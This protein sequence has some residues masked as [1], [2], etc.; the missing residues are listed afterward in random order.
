MKKHLFRI[1]MIIFSLLLMIGKSYASSLGKKDIVIYW[2]ASNS[3]GKKNKT[4]EFDFL[5]SFFKRTP[6]VEVTLF[7]FNTSIILEESLKVED[8]NWNYLKQLLSNVTYDGDSDFSLVNTELSTELLF[9]FTDGKCNFG[10]FKASLYSPRIITISSQFDIDKKFLHNTAYYNRG[11]YVNLLESDISSS[12][13]AVLAEETLAKLEFIGAEEK[14]YSQKYIKGIVTDALDVLPNVNVMILEKNIK[15][16]TD[17]FGRYSIKAD[18]G[19]VL[20]FSSIDKKN[21]MVEVG[22]EDIIDIR[23]ID[24]INE[25]EPVIIKSKSN[26]D[27]LEIRIGDKWVNRNS[28]GYDVKSLESKDFN[29][30]SRSLGDAIAGKFAGVKMGNDND[31]GQMIIRSNMSYL[32]S[33]NPVFV[34]DGVPLTR[35]TIPLSL[36][37]NNKQPISEATAYEGKKNFNFLDPNS[38]QSIT[39][40][41][42][43]AATNRYGQLGNNGIVLITTKVA[44]NRLNLSQKQESLQKMKYDIYKLP[45]FINNNPKSNFITILEKTSSIEQGYQQYLK[46]KNFHR[47]NVTFFIESAEFFFSKGERGIGFRIL[48]NL[49]ELFPEDTSVLKILAFHLE[50]YEM[51]EQAQD[52]YKLI[53]EISPTISQAYL[54]LANSYYDDGKHQKSVDLFLKISSK[55]IRKVKSFNGLQSQINNDFKSLLSHR[56]T[57][58]KLN[59]IEPKYFNLPKY[60]IRIVTEWSHPQTEFE[61]Q[62]INP[63]KQ[64]FVLSH[65]LEKYKKVMDREW[66]EEFTSEE[67]IIA[68]AEKGK[69]F[70]GLKSSLEHNTDVKYPKFLKVK[71]YTNFGG[72]QEK[73]QTHII[74]LDR[75]SEDKIFAYFTVQ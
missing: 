59:K 5:D 33:S 7:I 62:Y 39:V 64:Y 38:I 16:I 48:S 30:L 29:N 26:N 28:V 74:N 40:L 44:E 21:V 1:C 52:I 63:K 15:T 13:Q 45:L 32:L 18:R 53:I 46:L 47:D 9:F 71:I 43:L 70:L 54:D 72:T 60:D 10:E 34:V 66:A 42:G 61:M 69:W 20:L 56:S 36:A 31:L 25:L 19:D 41:K 4:K 73:L 3:Q 27:D 12:V 49:S 23:M 2:D 22:E 57:G 24:Q 11:Y 68:N 75:V 37:G 55:K 6:N 67:Y 58:W 17:Q 65:T 51:F 8:S 14:N 50:K 35:S